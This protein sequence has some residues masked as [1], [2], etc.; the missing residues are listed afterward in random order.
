MLGSGLDLPALAARQRASGPALWD[1]DLT[2]G[3]LPPVLSLAR[4]TGAT[5]VGATGLITAAAV[6]EPRFDADPITHAVRGLLLEPQATYFGARSEDVA[7]SPWVLSSGL[8]N[9]AVTMDSPLRAADTVNRLGGGSQAYS[10]AQYS[11]V[12]TNATLTQHWLVRNVDAVA[13]RVSYRDNVTTVQIDMSITWASAT[14]GAAIASV[15]VSTGAGVTCTASG[16]WNYG[17][18]WWLVWA[19][20][21]T[22]ALNG[23][24]VLRFAPAQTT[25]GR[26]VDVAAAWATY[27]D[28]P[29]SYTPTTTVPVTRDADALT[30]LDTS[31]AVEITYSPLAGGAAQTVQ[32]A[33][34]AQPGALY[35][36]LTRVRQL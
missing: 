20:F 33:A 32:V 6:N 23:A 31:R 10:A 14:A 11:T 36:R 25:I 29:Q 17:G 22:G 9:T 13:S 19:T 27:T 2:L 30:L 1:Y 15:A 3:V 5:Y 26:S 12:P 8:L 35:G 7:T 24:N 21:T 18:G 16:Y 28:A 34:G 4:A